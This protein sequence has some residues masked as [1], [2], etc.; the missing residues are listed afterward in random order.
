MNKS[1]QIGIGALVISSA[2]IAKE[3]KKKQEAPNIIFFLADDCTFRDIGCY[4][5][6]DAITPRIDNFAKEGMRFTQCFQAVA[7]SS[8]TRSNLYTGLYPVK[9]GAYPNH[10]FVKDGVQSIVQHLRPK[11]Y[12]TALL[13]KTHI[14]PRSA[15][16]FNYLGDSDELDFN[17]MESYIGDQ[18]RKNEPFCLFVCSH[19][20]HG[21]YTQGDPSR[22]PEEK[23]TIHPY[24]VDTKETRKVFSQILAEIEY[25][26]GEFGQCLD[27]LEK[28]GL[29]DNTIVVFASEQ[30]NGLPFAKFTCYDNG[31]QSAFVVRWPG[32]VKPGKESNA[33]IE[34]C[35]VTPTLMDIAGVEV[36]KE[37]DGKS[38]LP[39]LLGK[40]NKH[41]EYVYGI[42]TT[43]GVIGCPTFYGSR[44][45][46]SKKFKY[47][48]NLT[49]DETFVNS[50]N[51]SSVFKSWQ[52]KALNDYNASL[53]AN[54]YLKRP[55]EE[56]YNVERDPFELNNLANNPAYASQMCELK[57]KLA[58]WMKQQGDKGQETELDASNRQT[59]NMKK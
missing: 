18:K 41:K 13:G 39:V 28:Y 7:M 55:A 42:Q 25:M 56:L 53:L 48:L 44:S 29:S 10:T 11:G 31:L 21:P 43:R 15:F 26:D 14:N 22:F 40:T 57:A 2:A 50:T 19:Q 32:K 47:I 4:G 16:P 37:L 23:L 38:F 46:R 33:M 27:I 30:G 59:V 36:N 6:K 45:V 5:S 9:S 49:P 12:N 34:Y 20:P 54:K 1:V 24:L 8:P 35:D 51:N 52:K 3:P 17:K 58:D